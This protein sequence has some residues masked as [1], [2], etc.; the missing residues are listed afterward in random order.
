[1]YIA[2]CHDLYRRY[3]IV[4]L[5]LCIL[6]ICGYVISSFPGS[7][8]RMSNSGNQLHVYTLCI[9][10]ESWTALHGSLILCCKNCY[11]GGPILHPQ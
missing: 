2:Q 4:T 3:I 10:V 11:I 9:H 8:Y 7:V 5:K 1:M 6:L